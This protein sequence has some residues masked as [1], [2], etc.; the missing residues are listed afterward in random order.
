MCSVEFAD[1]F[2]GICQRALAFRSRGAHGNGGDGEAHAGQQ[3]GAERR[4]ARRV[5]Q[6]VHAVRDCYH[7]PH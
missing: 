4:D 2:R 7:V 1:A 3:R 6:H 5:H